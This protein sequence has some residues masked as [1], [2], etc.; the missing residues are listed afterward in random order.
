MKV[1]QLRRS[2][3][4]SAAERC[5]SNRRVDATEQR[6]GLKEQVSDVSDQGRVLDLE[7]FGA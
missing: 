3:D 7:T 6:S 4:V 5:S 2:R 1:W